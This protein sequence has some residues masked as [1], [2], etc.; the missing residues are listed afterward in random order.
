MKDDFPKSK[1]CQVRKVSIFLDISFFWTGEHLTTSPPDL[2][3]RLMLANQNQDL[4]ELRQADDIYQSLQSL[5]IFVA[6]CPSSVLDMDMR[7]LLCHVVSLN[8]FKW[9]FL[10]IQLLQREILVKF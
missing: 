7:G 8:G 5:C 6:H 2:G 1:T 10:D 9:S 3:D 4:E